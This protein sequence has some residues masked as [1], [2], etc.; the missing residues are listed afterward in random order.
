[1]GEPDNHNQLADVLIGEEVIAFPLEVRTPRDIGGLVDSDRF[2]LI[3]EAID[4]G[5]WNEL[6]QEMPKIDN[7]QDFGTQ[8]PRIEELVFF[9]GRL[10]DHFGH[11]LLESLSRLWAYE[12]FRQFDPYLFFY[13]PWGMP[14]YLEKN[15]Y[16]YQVLSGFNIPHHKIIFTDHPIRLR[17]VVI[18][19]QKYGRHSD[20]KNPE[21]IFLDFIK[22]F[23]FQQV[24]PLG[25]E[26]A[27]KVY[28][29]RSKLGANQGKMIG[30]SLF[31]EYLISEGYK[32]F[33][34]EKFTFFEQLTVYQNAKKII[35]SG[36]SAGHAC[37]LLPDLQANV[38]VIFRWPGNKSHWDE[39]RQG[40][41]DQF[42][43]YGKEVLSVDTVKGQYR[44]GLDPWS[45]L[46]TIDWYQA[47]IMLQKQG[48]ISKPFDQF[49]EINEGD[50]TKRDL[51]IYIKE[52][53][54]RSEF[55]DFMLDLQDLG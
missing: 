42:R 51:E 46:S 3:E 55:L 22:K 34:P 1:M 38:A 31:E 45:G 8:L 47:S 4:R 37:L 21:P 27:D 32:I 30:E 54:S 6:Y 19:C 23:Q 14:N 16:I 9:G 10:N 53:A 28:V 36:G 43:A 25:F 33:Y 12:A 41:V 17:K 18:P 39:V 29:S 35:F 48:F 24:Q 44:F 11:F 40:I 5:Y 2:Q 50:L 26:N 15:N 20:I 7:I 13:T 52:I 49:K